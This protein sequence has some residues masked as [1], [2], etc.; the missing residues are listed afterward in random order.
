MNCFH[1][2]SSSYHKHLYNDSS[3]S[4]SFH[5]IV[6]VDTLK[7]SITTSLNPE[8]PVLHFI[9]YKCRTHHKYFITFATSNSYFVFYL[10]FFFV[11]DWTKKSKIIYVFHSYSVWLSHFVTSCCSIRVSFQNADFFFEDHHLTLKKN[12]F[13]YISLTI[14]T[15]CKPLIMSFHICISRDIMT[16]SQIPLSTPSNNLAQVKSQ[17]GW[18][19]SQG[20]SAGHCTI[21]CDW[22]VIQRH[23]TFIPVPVK[24][25]RAQ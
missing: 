5:I 3:I 6:S 7:L 4:L 24:Q 25:I 18:H 16:D 22:G 8:P 13:Q 23:N 19:F 17:S 1:H 21:N 15:Y 10:Q 11:K 9:I 14:N 20:V 12:Y 2:P